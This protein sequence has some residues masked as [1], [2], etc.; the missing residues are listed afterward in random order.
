MNLQALKYIIEIEKCGSIS[1]AAK[2]LYLSQPYLSKLVKETESEYQ[3]TLFTRS[4]KGITLTESG[5]LFVDMGRNLQQQI[6]DFQNVFLSH[7]KGTQL[8]ISSCI[9]SHPC[10]ALIRM[11]Q[12]EEAEEYLRCT[13]REVSNDE[14]IDDV[15]TNVSDIGILLL[16]NSSLNA[17]Q[18][19][20]KTKQIACHIIFSSKVYLLA[21]KGHPL[22]TSG[23][24]ITL[25]DVYQYNFVI[26]SGKRRERGTAPIDVYSDDMMSL[27]NWDR[28]H[29][30]V[31][32]TSRAALRDILTRTDYLAIG[33]VDVQDQ[34]S[35]MN[36]WTIPLPE[37]LS[38]PQPDFG[39]YICYIHLK[40]R[41]LP[42]GCKTFI[43]YLQKYYGHIS[44]LPFP[45]N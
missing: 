20:M 22:F 9:F 42:M 23:N 33:I 40:N 3:I 12:S 17:A 41:K 16:N 10:D 6:D 13:F 44:E 24:P 25:E 34:E 11:F 1:K 29:Q 45:E 8:R 39:H 27:I 30:I 7:S 21:R 36:L 14:V 28:I 4:K 19:T 38:L 5:R 32:V 43:H 2:N 18:W 15:Y 37:E 31:Y 35:N 26:Y